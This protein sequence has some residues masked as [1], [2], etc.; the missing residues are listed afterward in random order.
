MKIKVEIIEG[1]DSI[2]VWTEGHCLGVFK[3]GIEG[4]RDA[5]NIAGVACHLLDYW[6]GS[7]GFHTKLSHELNGYSDKVNKIK[8]ELTYGRWNYFYAGLMSGGLI[9][10][11]II[12]IVRWISL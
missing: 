4:K 5:I 2:R 7:Y 11:T 12:T 10:I 6:G 1:K 9:V 8:H 3:K